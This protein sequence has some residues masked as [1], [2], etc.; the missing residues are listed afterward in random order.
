MLVEKVEAKSSAAHGEEQFMCHESSS[1]RHWI[2]R[3]SLMR[4]CAW[5]ESSKMHASGEA[6]KR[7]YAS[8]VLKR[9][10]Q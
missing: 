9:V 4:A 1:H 10:P 5:W 6:H 2:A 8:C 3:K 7:G